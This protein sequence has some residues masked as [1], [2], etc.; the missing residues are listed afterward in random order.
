MT[1]R[2]LKHMQEYFTDGLEGGIFTTRSA[3]LLAE[4]C[5]AGKN[6]H[7]GR[8]V[9]GNAS[10]GESDGDQ[11]PL[12]FVLESLN[13][14]YLNP[15][16]LRALPS[17]RPDVVAQ[18][19]HLPATDDAYFDRFICRTWVDQV[20][21]HLRA[22]LSPLLCLPRLLDKARK[23]DAWNRLKGDPLARAMRL[24]RMGR[25]VYLLREHKH[26]INVE[27]M[28][29]AWAPLVRWWL[30]CR[31]IE[32]QFLRWRRRRTLARCWHCWQAVERRDP[33]AAAHV[34]RSE[35]RRRAEKRSMM[36]P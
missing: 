1:V 29:R 18:A 16:L 36:P 23:R 22:L 10:D 11:H 9:A 17:L 30:H 15:E 28:R 14:A 34:L 8:K 27:T 7:N 25:L 31:Q 32:A 33:A 3:R 5:A 12:F 24:A 13:F 26:K 6:D 35:G 21:N 20:E 2:A 4:T 19:H